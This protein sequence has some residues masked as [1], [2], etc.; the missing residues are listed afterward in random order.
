VKKGEIKTG[1]NWVQRGVCNLLTISRH[2]AMR[3]RERDGSKNKAERMILK[4]V[5]RRQEERLMMNFNPIDN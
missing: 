4:L 1:G 2:E 5:R 3:D